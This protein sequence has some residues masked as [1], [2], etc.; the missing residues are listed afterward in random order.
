M[1]KPAERIYEIGTRVQN[2]LERTYHPPEW[3]VC[4]LAFVPTSII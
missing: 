1:G 2:F 4:K 3:E